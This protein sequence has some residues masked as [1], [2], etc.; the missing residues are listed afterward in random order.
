MRRNSIAALLVLL[1]AGCAASAQ[2]RPA[3]VN[4]DALMR[5]HPLY[6]TLGQYDRQ[7]AVL[8][9]TLRTQFSNAGAAIDNASSAVR[10]DLSAASQF[11]SRSSAGA[12]V[13]AMANLS[14]AAFAAKLDDN[15]RRTYEAQH[16]ALQGT[17]QQHM[18]AYRD[19]LIAQEQQAFQTFVSSVDGR[20]QRAYNARAQELREKESALLLKLAQQDAEQRLMLR[21]KL[22]TLAL[23]AERR[24]QL[25][26]QLRA[27]QAREDAA[28]ASMRRTDAGTLSAYEQHLRRK[29]DSDIAQMQTALQNRAAANLAARERVLE[30]QT[31]NA[32]GLQVPAAPA[33]SANSREMQS[34]YQSLQQAK[35]QDT[36]AYGAASRDLTQRFAGL[37]AAYDADTQSVRSQIASLEH[38]KAALRKKMMAQI[39]SE[40]EQVAKARGYSA[41][42]P[43]SS[44]PSGSADVTAA[45]AAA[46]RSLAP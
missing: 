34:A 44:A 5:R 1:L 17:A 43:A 20:T 41:V 23:S 7:I 46:L 38:D 8:Q 29:A 18:A 19:T 4:L 40:A 9:G 32:S 6:S 37:R 35:P 15:I 33:N 26:S 3:S 36:A 25:R 11:V 28:V 13:P 16:A 10:R 24:A 39:M 12:P 22:Q 42:Y 30:A 21:A 31:A 14:Q 27:L 2:T 45:V